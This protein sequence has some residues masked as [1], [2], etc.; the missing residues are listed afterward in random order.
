MFPPAYSQRRRIRRKGSH[1]TAERQH[2]QSRKS[3]PLDSMNKPNTR[4]CLWVVSAWSDLG[5]QA[6][7]EMLGLNTRRGGRR[8][9]RKSKSNSNSSSSSSR[10]SSK[11]T[12]KPEKSCFMTTRHHSTASCPTTTEAFTEL[13]E[14]LPLRAKRGPGPGRKQHEAALNEAPEGLSAI[15]LLARR[16]ARAIHVTTCRTIKSVL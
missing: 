12:H 3:S 4:S 2:S 10:S 1:N 6:L 8:R 7:R 9:R 11:R 15:D 14:E 16:S 13:S 5:A